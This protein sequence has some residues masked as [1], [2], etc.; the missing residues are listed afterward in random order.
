MYG[1]SI[2]LQNKDV[3]VKIGLNCEE[4]LVK[5]ISDYAIENPDYDIVLYAHNG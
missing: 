1:F 5:I 3:I 2:K 4:E